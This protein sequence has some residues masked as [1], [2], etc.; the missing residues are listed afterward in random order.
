MDI[1]DIIRIAK[2]S[3]AEGI[4][5]GYGF[6]SEN[7][8]FAKRCAE[9]GLV[10][11]GPNVHHLD[12]F[13]DKIK[14]KEA[15]IAAGIQSIP[16]TDGPVA[17]ID[18]VLAFAA[19]HGYPIMI[20]AALGGGGRG[21][22]VAHDEKEAKDGY[23]R[24]KSEA[25]AAFGSDEVYV[26]KYIGNPKHIEVQILGDNHGNI[27]HL[28]ERDCSVQRRH[29]KVV[30]VAPCV[31][32]N[33]AKRE[34]ICQ[35]AVQLMKHV[36]YI[37]AGTVEFLVEEDQFYFIEVNPR[38]QVEHTIT[39]MITDIDIVT[40]QILIA[41]GKNLHT[42][43]GIPKQEAITYKGAAI[44]CR[45][46]TEDPVNNFMPD[47]G[48]IDTYRSPGG[49]GVRLDV[50]NAYAGAIVTPYFDSLLV[51]VCTHASTF[52]QAI[53]KMQRCLRE[54][55]IRGVK[56]NMPFM[57]NVI[58]HPEFQSGDAKTTFIDN[59]PALFVFPSTRDRG[60]KTMKYISEITINGFPGIEKNKKKYYGE[61]RLP[62][63]LIEPKKN[64]LSA[65]NI[66][67]DKGADAVVNWVK[68]QKK[69]L[70][71]DTT[72]RDAHQSLLA[73]RV[74]THDFEKIAAKTQIA[75]PELFSAEMWGGATFDV[76]YRFLNEDP[77][78]RLKTLRKLMPN[79]LFQMLFRGSNAV[80]Y[81]NYPDNVIAEFIKEAAKQGIDV[82]R[83]FDSL[84]W[85]PQ[86]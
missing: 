9:E 85:L 10:F 8:A 32:L 15:A 46:T 17:S 33:D 76:A 73:T 43:I 86:M 19:T 67:D 2:E 36:G 41:E 1:E 42:E 40:S 49:F 83:I 25:K 74:R 45:I 50:G 71:T 24:A 78:V 52:E 39:E 82:F 18:E 77:W 44:Q 72:F 69:L 11:I 63:K 66:L 30:E 14:A 51:K 22:R 47:T 60:N 65:K 58:N 48:K 20:K 84:N 16:G 21:M 59:T 13:G 75:L 55:R 70:L 29:Q 27:V 7:L 12:I 23:E 37:N 3:G 5:P 54:F 64:I 57:S 53:Q 26:E 56:T 62:H 31:S 61:A 38:V 4:H 81:S 80:G 68:D 28:F 79:T 34:E 6:L 35:A